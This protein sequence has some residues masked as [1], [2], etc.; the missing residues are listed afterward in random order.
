MEDLPTQTR[1][2]E[3]W[4]ERSARKGYAQWA[5]TKG[6]ETQAL[7]AGDIRFVQRELAQE[8]IEELIAICH[9][10]PVRVRCL[11]WAQAQIL[12]VG[13]SVAGGVQWKDWEAIYR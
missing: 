3:D 5:T 4:S 6:W 12:P 7:C 11:L 10:C 8:I 2:S 13:F 1:L 9:T